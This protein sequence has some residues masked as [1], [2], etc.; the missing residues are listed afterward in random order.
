[1]SNIPV[2]PSSTPDEN[3]SPPS[4]R[5][6][7]PPNP[8]EWELTH[9]QQW[10]RSIG[11]AKYAPRFEDDMIDGQ[12]LLEDVDQKLLEDAFD[13]PKLHAKKIM[14]K[15][16]GLRAE[17]EYD[18]PPIPKQRSAD[19]ASLQKSKSDHLAR[20]RLLQE[21]KNELEVNQVN[22]EGAAMEASR[23]RKKQISREIKKRL[24]KIKKIDTVLK[25]RPSH[26]ISSEVELIEDPDNNK[27]LQQ[28]KQANAEKRRQSAVLD[29]ELAEK[30]KRLQA[31][32]ERL[33]A[34]QK[35]ALEAAQ[36]AP[37]IEPPV[38]NFQTST[39]KAT[40]KSEDDYDF[41]DSIDE[42]LSDLADNDNLDD[43]SDMTD[44]DEEPV[45]G[46]IPTLNR[47]MSVSDRLFAN[48]IGSSSSK[49]ESQE[50]GDPSVP[51]NWSAD[52]VGEWLE[53]IGFPQYSD[54]FST[55][56]VTGHVLLSHQV[57]ERY[58]KN[59][60]HV[61]ENDLK[62]LMAKINDLKLQHAPSLT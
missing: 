27:K 50:D 49:Q 25:N 3:N 17:V 4:N 15:I 6:P 36:K 13:I 51:T 8:R 60:I 52:R 24:K 48:L 40:K 59:I 18:E 23:K 22:L 46:F 7:T 2:S 34:Q 5:L 20:I 10:L 19:I 43:L 33:K 55:M 45:A 9:V 29:Q 39:R 44:E 28:I 58:L 1:M 47:N 12:I 11:M 14:S 32:E 56:E 53:E 31:M 21:Q 16:V 26:A 38:R 37:P 41:E 42:S 57:N 62:P 54:D 30:T 35:A 61:K